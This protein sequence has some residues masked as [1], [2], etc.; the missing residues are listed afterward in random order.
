MKNEH[1]IYISIVSKALINASS[2]MFCFSISPPTLFCLPLL[3]PPFLPQVYMTLL[4][5]R[6]R[7]LA[8]PGHFVPGFGL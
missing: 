8:H 7:V 1:I 5:F 3:P 6:K 4:P 2:L